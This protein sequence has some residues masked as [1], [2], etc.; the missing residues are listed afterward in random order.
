MARVTLTAVLLLALVGEVASAAHRVAC[1]ML[2]RA[3]AGAEAGCEHCPPPPPDVALRPA[4]PDC[5]AFHAVTVETAV[6]EPV[7]AS[8]HGSA[9]ALPA[10][11]ARVTPLALPVLHVSPLESRAPAPSPPPRNLPLLS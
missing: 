10:P 6:S 4:L 1:P 2:E 5:C 9:V 7:R 11:R 8:S 3:R